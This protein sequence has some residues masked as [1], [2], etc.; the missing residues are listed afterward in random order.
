MTFLSVAA[1]PGAAR[2]ARTLPGS[3]TSRTGYDPIARGYAG[4]CTAR[5]RGDERER[6]MGLSDE[7]ITGGSSVVGEG[8]ADG[9][10]NPEGQ[11]GGADGGA[12]AGSANGGANPA[13]H[14]SGADA[15]AGAE[16][17]ADGGANPAG[18]D[19]GADGSAY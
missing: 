7:D 12:V 4:V 17:P 11:D 16:G 2:A 8:V 15:G 9:G 10:A 3:L 6:T 1:A 18:Q 14:D 13:G 5:R 19:G